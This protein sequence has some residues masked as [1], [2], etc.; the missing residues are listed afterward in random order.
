MQMKLTIAFVLSALTSGL[1]LSA[2]T[3]RTINPSNVVYYQRS[4]DSTTPSRQHQVKLPIF[5]RSN[6]VDYTLSHSVKRANTPEARPATPAEGGDGGASSSSSSSHNE[7]PQYQ[8]DQAPDPNANI[9]SQNHPNSP[10]GKNR[11]DQAT[12]LATAASAATGL[13][14]LGLA[15]AAFAGTNHTF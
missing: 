12:A 8:G 6:G 11:Y 14:S 4:V 9:L 10:L 5:I 2:P 13:T 7:E 3:Q 15:G 1:V